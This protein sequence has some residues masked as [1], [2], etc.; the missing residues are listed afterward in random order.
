MPRSKEAVRRGNLTRVGNK[1]AKDRRAAL[2]QEGGHS[3]EEIRREEEVARQEARDERQAQ[4]DREDGGVDGNDEVLDL[5][6]REDT[7]EQRPARERQ[8]ARIRHRSRSPSRSLSPPRRRRDRS[9]LLRRRSDRRRS[10]RH[11]EPS[12]EGDETWENDEYEDLEERRPRRVERRGWTEPQGRMEPLG[13][14]QGHGYAGGQFGGAFGGAQRGPQGG[15][16]GGFQGSQGFGFQEGF[17]SN[18]RPIVDWTTGMM[19]QRENG[20]ILPPA[21]NQAF[22]NLLQNPSFP[23]PHSHRK[24]ATQ[25]ARNTFSPYDLVKLDRDGRLIDESEER[26]SLDKDL[27]IRKGGTKSAKLFGSDSKKWSRTFLIYM[28]YLVAFHGIQY[29]YL[30]TAVTEFHARIVVLAED[31]VWSEVVSM[32]LVYHQMAL[33]RFGT[34]DMTAWVIPES[35][36]LSY[37]RTRTVKSATNRSGG[38]GGGGRPQSNRLGKQICYTWNSEAGCQDPECERQHKCKVCKSTKHTALECKEKDKKK[39]EKE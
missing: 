31:Y 38:I 39:K 27:T 19:G 28:T 26:F 37:L 13:M 3:E 29:P 7:P 22:Y 4:Y 1:A 20:E 17:A 6:E 33:D 18:Q 5:N 34:Q 25:I 32:A 10:V 14:P 16:Q 36:I 9:P 23:L 11:R 35:Q 24:Y 15:F 21:Y 30:H 8:E 12:F 2:R